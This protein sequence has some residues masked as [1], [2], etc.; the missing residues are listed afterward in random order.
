MCISKT[1]KKKKLTKKVTDEAGKRF[2][3]QMGKKK[4]WLV[5]LGSH[6]EGDQLTQLGSL[7]LDGS[8]CEMKEAAAVLVA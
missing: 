2:D 8:T 4:G 3:A 1:Q 5:Q 7:T 6:E